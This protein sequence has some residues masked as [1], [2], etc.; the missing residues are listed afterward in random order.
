MKQPIQ[1]TLTEEDIRHMIA[2]HYKTIFGPEYKV[3]IDLKQVDGK[4]QADV[5][6]N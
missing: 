2:Q 3:N 5:E 1:R 6:L 4:L